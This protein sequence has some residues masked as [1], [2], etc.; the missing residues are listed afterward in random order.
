MYNVRFPIIG[1]SLDGSLI[2]EVFKYGAIIIFDESENKGIA[3][4][5]V[6][7]QAR[8][9]GLFG[10]RGEIVA[11]PTGKAFYYAIGLWMRGLG[12]F[13]GVRPGG[14]ETIDRL[15]TRRVAGGF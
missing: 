7:Q 6:R 15:F 5:M 10:G 11:D 13:V 8:T 2:L 3:G 4:V 9:V 1:K 14:A 12:Q